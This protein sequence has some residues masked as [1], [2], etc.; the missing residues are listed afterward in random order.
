MKIGLIARADNTGLGMQ[1]WEFYRHMK[2]AKT[3]VIDMET[4]NGFAPHLDRYPDATVSK[5]IPMPTELNAFLKDLDVVF[6]CETPYSF[7]LIEL[8]KFM[9]VKVVIQPNYEFNKWLANPKLAKPDMFGLPSPW[10]YDKLPKDWPVVG[11]PVPIATDRLKLNDRPDTAKNF[12]HVVGKPAANDRNGT[13]ILLTALKHVNEDIRLTL[14]TQRPVETRSL[15]KKAY[16]PRNVHIVIKE[17]V[18][19]YWDLYE[20]Q[21]CLIMPRRYGGLCLPANE[22]IGCG[23]PVIMPDI[24][25]NNTWLP[26]DWLVPAVKQGKFMANVEVEMFRMRPKMLARKIDKMARS[27]HFY[28]GSKAAAEV[29]RKEYS[30]NNQWA[31]YVAVFEDVLNS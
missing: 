1:T 19:N 20:G 5:G 7:Q 31:H 28:A 11:L 3:L 25:P 29:I 18:D 14:T 30:W 10:N 16:V 15:V 6:T 2:P 22:A 12:L 23:M 4:N 13:D 21:H 8:A 17:P 27:P 9:G 24:D 26:S